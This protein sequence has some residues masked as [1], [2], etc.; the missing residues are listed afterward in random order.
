MSFWYFWQIISCYIKYVKLTKRIFLVALNIR[1]ECYN[2]YKYCILHIL[3][4]VDLA[5][6][7][8]K[9]R[10]MNFMLDFY[11]K[12]LSPIYSSSAISFCQWPFSY[13]EKKKHAAIFIATIATVSLNSGL[14]FRP[15][16]RSISLFRIYANQNIKRF[17]KTSFLKWNSILPSSKFTY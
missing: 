6:G 4:Q 5:N 1:N 8:N 15:K 11:F 13:K 10:K 12:F 14:V 2:I 7:D 9:K 3:F 17:V 16:G